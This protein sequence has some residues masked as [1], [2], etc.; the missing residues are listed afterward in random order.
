MKCQPYAPSP[1]NPRSTIPAAVAIPIFAPRERVR[2]HVRIA[3]RRFQSVQHTHTATAPPMIAPVI[4]NQLGR[5]KRK[6]VTAA[7][8]PGRGDGAGPVRSVTIVS[9]ACWSI[10]P[11]AGGRGAH[12]SGGGSPPE[13]GATVSYDCRVV[14]PPS[15]RDFLRIVLLHLLDAVLQQLLHERHVVRCR[16]EL[17]DGR[18]K[19]EVR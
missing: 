7:R 3:A 18:G 8:P 6:R 19:R 17:G 12:A 10:E 2:S 4:W 16:A 13:T 5:L 11:R 15:S 14:L 9:C 1:A